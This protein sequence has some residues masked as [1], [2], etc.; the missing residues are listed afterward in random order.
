[1][2][3]TQLGV[4]LGGTA[5]EASAIRDL[6]TR[7][8]RPANELLAAL[9]SLK[10]RGSHRVLKSILKGLQG[11]WKEGKIEDYRK[12]LA[13]IR[14][15]L[16]L[17]MLSIINQQ[18]EQQ[19]ETLQHLPALRKE[20]ASLKA[21]LDTNTNSELLTALE[22]RFSDATQ[23]IYKARAF[24]KILDS[25]VYKEI[26]ARE[27]AIA[28]AHQSTFLWALQNIDQGRSSKHRLVRWLQKDE[29]LFWVTG[30]PGSGKSTFMKFIFDHKKTLQFL[31]EWAGDARLCI[32]R[33]YFWRGGTRLQKSEEG[34]LRSILYDVLSQAPTLICDVVDPSRWELCQQNI[35]AFH[36]WLM[37]ELQESVNRLAQN[38]M[39]QLKFCL[40]IDGLDEYEGN[41]SDLA[42][43]LKRLSSSTN[44]K[45][46]VASRELNAFRTAFGHDELYR[47][48][49][50]EL[51]SK[52]ID[53]FV[54]Y[55]FQELYQNDLIQSTEDAQVKKLAAIVRSKAQGVFLWVNLT[56]AS[57]R[58]GF[59]NG[60]SFDEQ[61]SRLECL[62]LDLENLIRHIFESIEPQYYGKLKRLLSLCE[63][64]EM[65][66][67]SS[68]S[69]PLATVEFIGTA[70]LTNFG[71]KI[72]QTP[73][74]LRAL[75]QTYRK[76][77]RQLWA[78]SN[79]L[80]R[81]HSYV[82]RN[83]Q[84]EVDYD[85]P[86][87]VGRQVDANMLVNRILSAKIA[88]THR[89]IYE[90]LRCERPRKVLRSYPA[91]D[92][93]Q[94][95]FLYTQSLL[96]TLKRVDFN[97]AGIVARKFGGPWNINFEEHIRACIEELAEIRGL[98]S[99][100][101]VSWLDLNQRTKRIPFSNPVHHFSKWF[102]PIYTCCMI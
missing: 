74:T 21:T 44:V 61:Q 37:R 18:Q 91:L 45:V 29:N 66:A 90:F 3:A 2:E 87:L 53:A 23:N 72:D 22:T 64:L 95:C 25:L 89:S 36:P 71:I 78:I 101:T 94:C 11:L 31:R 70:E 30:L 86:G 52:D 40:F 28:P 96:A 85:F 102:G 54:D 27:S 33:H 12:R 8:I 62:P 5:D 49:L 48:H 43:T 24:G 93:K 19:R 39:N 99:T 42:K 98:V 34:L 14:Q 56:M 80:L 57:L 55:G 65:R 83:K 1:M 41:H 88:V 46:C 97:M 82:P 60:D 16:V 81:E 51:T 9:Q 76:Q 59:E 4:T 69:I 84:I 50:H 15:E 32:A 20:L 73:L 68:D 58:R 63:W 47:L 26:K 92:E 6:A 79:G 7:S 10:V 13:E 77:Q 67:S 38:E 100:M 75:E 35:E 17:R